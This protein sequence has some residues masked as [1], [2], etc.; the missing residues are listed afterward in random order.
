MTT[1]N[2]SVGQTELDRLA[3]LLMDRINGLEKSIADRF[4]SLEKVSTERC[5]RQV[6]VFQTRQQELSERIDKVESH[7]STLDTLTSEAVG[8]AKAARLLG[9]IASTVLTILIGLGGFYLSLHEYDVRHQVTTI[10]Q[11]QQQLD[12]REAL[13]KIREEALKKKEAEAETKADKRTISPIETPYG[14]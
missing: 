1:S 8:M 14:D 2:G 4:D 3:K 9:I 7:V 11:R 13:L 10:S 12:Q 5:N 6:G